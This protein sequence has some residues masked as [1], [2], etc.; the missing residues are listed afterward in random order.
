MTNLSSKISKTFH[1]HGIHRKKVFPKSEFK[2][3]VD[4]S[5]S[6]NR[7]EDFTMGIDD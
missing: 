6:S 5:F 7:Y 3:I 1:R 4:I 2:L